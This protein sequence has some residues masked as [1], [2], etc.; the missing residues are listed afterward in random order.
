MIIPKRKELKR[1]TRPFKDINNWLR[2][3][4]AKSSL[5]NEHFP[6]V[7]RLAVVFLVVLGFVLFL[8]TLASRNYVQMEN[9]LVR[10]QKEEEWK[11]VETLIYE[12]SDK[13]QEKAQSVAEKIT[14][15]LVKEYKDNNDQLKYDIDNLS[16]TSGLS[17][18]LD[19]NIKGK[20]LNYENEDNTIFVA[21]Q[22]GIVSDKSLSGADKDRTWTKEVSKSENHRLTAQMR[23]AL[24]G[25]KNILIFSESNSSENPNHYKMKEMRLDELRKLY[26]S[27][28][29][30]G[31]K[32]VRILV[33]AYITRTGDI[34]GVDDVDAIGNRQENH[35]LI[36]V[37]RFSIYD[38]ISTKYTDVSAKNELAIQK[39]H[40]DYN[41]RLI[42]LKISVVAVVL[43]LLGVLL[44]LNHYMRKQIERVKLSFPTNLENYES[45]LL[46]NK[47]EQ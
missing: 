20:Y 14:F 37:Q 17:I 15:E 19:N 34:F 1:V 2:K 28:G 4:S 43:L 16:P 47:K 36:V 38:I 30:N 7:A 23:D 25:Q 29:L 21:N 10:A 42:F 26:I 33:P 6:L 32:H 44:S 31:L 9:D 40:F 18:I 41:L 39:I 13:A 46:S 27:E 11:L 22:T 8:Y 12:N 35:K 45:I 24:I 5:T 3:E